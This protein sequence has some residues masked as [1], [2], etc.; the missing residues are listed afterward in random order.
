[1]CAFVRILQVYKPE[2]D[3]IQ[4]TENLEEWERNSTLVTPLFSDDTL[5]SLHWSIFHLAK[6]CQIK[7]C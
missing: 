6:A 5:G 4:D 7:I 1:M 2:G 3:K